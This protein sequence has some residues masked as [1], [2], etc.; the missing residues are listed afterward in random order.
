[1]LG[2]PFLFGTRAHK[3]KHEA[4]QKFDRQLTPG[5]ARCD[6]RSLLSL[7]LFIVMLYQGYGGYL[8][9]GVAP[10]Q[11]QRLKISLCRVVRLN[12]S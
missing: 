4:Y 11:L 1:M 9:I 6:V 10:L 3:A 7:R 5:S 12:N 2:I 8:P